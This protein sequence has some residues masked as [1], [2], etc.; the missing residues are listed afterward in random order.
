M[1]S[2]PNHPGPDHGRYRPRRTF[3][4]EMRARRLHAR[5][6]C[7]LQ[8]AVWAEDS[9]APLASGRIIDISLGGALLSCPAQLQ[10]GRTYRF[11]LS[12]NNARVSLAG[13]VIRVAGDGQ[14]NRYGISFSAASR[15]QDVLKSIIESL[16]ARPAKPPIPEDKLRWYWGT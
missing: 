8:A 5:F 6:A 9:R 3:D 11:Q 12:W 2:L 10:K 13:E 16:R 1:S 7:D 4:D 15:T 14:G